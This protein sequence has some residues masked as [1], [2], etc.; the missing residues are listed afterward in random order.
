MVYREQVGNSLALGSFSSL[1]HVSS[2]EYKR[3]EV[4][5]SVFLGTAS[6]PDPSGKSR[7]HGSCI[8]SQGS[9]SGS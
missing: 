4:K 8:V 6:Y 2:P 1:P 3:G 7:L 5:S 9:I